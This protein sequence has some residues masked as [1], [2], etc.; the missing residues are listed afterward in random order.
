MFGENSTAPPEA[1]AAAIQDA[2]PSYGVSV[3]VRRGGRPRFEV[4]TRND[5][6]PWCLISDDADEIRH[7]LEVNAHV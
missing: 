5:D 7:E 2:F 1:E 4:V 3:S 6:S